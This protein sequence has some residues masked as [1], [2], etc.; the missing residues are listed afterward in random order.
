MWLLLGCHGDTP[1]LFPTI[2]A[3]R[4]QIHG[5]FERDEIIATASPDVF[6]ITPTLA[7]MVCGCPNIS[8]MTF[9][10]PLPSKK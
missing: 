5:A 7:G 9:L 4:H 1:L 3:S 2:M 6:D 8:F 10:L